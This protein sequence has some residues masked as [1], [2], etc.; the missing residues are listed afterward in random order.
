LYLVGRT[1]SLP[2]VHLPHVSLVENLGLNKASIFG[3]G[4]L[5]FASGFVVVEVFSLLAPPGRRLR[6]GGAAGRQKLNKAALIVGSLV[7]LLEAGLGSLS[8]VYESAKAR[9]IPPSVAP[10]EWLVFVTLAAG[11]FAALGLGELMSRWGL[12]NGLV[13]LAESQLVAQ[14]TVPFL[15]P[16][17]TGHFVSTASEWGARARRWPVP[18]PD[19]WLPSLLWTAAL[20]AIAWLILSRVGAARGLDASGQG[21]DLQLPAL[22]QSPFPALT[23]PAVLGMTFIWPWHEGASLYPAGSGAVSSLRPRSSWR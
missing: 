20:V 19:A 5:G 2:F 11:S 17:V 9:A 6:E 10:P 18:S 14:V 22:P 13:L 4:I 8:V 1:V 12:G 15:R 7:T 3:V 21:F 16:L 23:S